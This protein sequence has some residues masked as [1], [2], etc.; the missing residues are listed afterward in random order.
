MRLLHEKNL[1][2][3]SRHVHRTSLAFARAR[4]RACGVGWGYVCLTAESVFKFVLFSLMHRRAALRLDRADLLATQDDMESSRQQPSRTRQLAIVLT[5]LNSVLLLL[6]N[7]T[8]T[9]SGP[10]ARGPQSHGRHN[11]LDNSKFYVPFDQ[12]DAFP[13]G[14]PS[15]NQPRP[16]LAGRLSACW[17]TTVRVRVWRSTVLGVD[18]LHDLDEAPQTPPR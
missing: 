18:F 15:V 9:F 16:P 4:A 2:S 11:L 10:Q 12:Y 7:T 3:D 17:C 1:N 14:C 13:R 6:F 8:R 5:I